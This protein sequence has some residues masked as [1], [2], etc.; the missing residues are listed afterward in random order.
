[1]NI[2]MN[3]Q[4]LCWWCGESLGGDAE[5]TFRN[6][7]HDGCKEKFEIEYNDS[8][9]SAYFQICRDK[10]HVKR[11]TR[12]L[13]RRLK[14]KLRDTLFCWISCHEDYIMSME[15]V[16]RKQ[17]Y[18][19]RELPSKYFGARTAIKRVFNDVEVCSMTDS[20]GGDVYIYIGN[21]QYLKLTISG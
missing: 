4:E 3:K 1:M 2:K 21:L 14:P 13:G 20:F 11:L 18:G 5:N 19:C 7:V 15:I 16:S 8:M 10:K 6:G 17:C 9:D 12:K